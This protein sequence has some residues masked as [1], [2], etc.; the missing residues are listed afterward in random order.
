[1]PKAAHRAL[2]ASARKKGLTG[3]DYDKYVYGG[4]ENMEKGK[5]G[6]SGGK[7]RKGKK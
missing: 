6:K 7:S 2:A 4:L 5:R 3:K 1:M